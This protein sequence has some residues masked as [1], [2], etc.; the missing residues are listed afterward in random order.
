MAKYKWAWHIYVAL[1]IIQKEGRAE[2][3]YRTD[4]L[5]CVITFMATLL[6]SLSLCVLYILPSC[7]LYI[8]VSQ[9]SGPRDYVHT[10]AVYMHTYIHV[11]NTSSEVHMHWSSC[12]TS[13][14]TDAWN[15]IV[16]SVLLRHL[17]EYTHTSTAICKTI[18]CVHNYDWIVQ[19]S[20]LLVYT[21]KGWCSWT[22]I[23][24][25]QL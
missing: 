1:V 19:H 15:E 4:Y 14:K 18:L 9:G 16:L 5:D 2:D 3:R 8:L 12:T 24:K 25:F 20:W 13:N 21:H 11:R 22:A 17:F 7:V 6:N 23:C 10:W